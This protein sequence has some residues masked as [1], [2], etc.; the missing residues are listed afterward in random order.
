MKSHPDKV[1]ASVAR[2]YRKQI[3]Y[4]LENRLGL[5][6]Y[7]CPLFNPTGAARVKGV[8]IVFPMSL[9]RSIH[10][11]REAQGRRSAG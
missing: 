8:V 6:P 4:E 9:Y 11:R 5:H 1:M 3:Q 2:H 10:D 7:R